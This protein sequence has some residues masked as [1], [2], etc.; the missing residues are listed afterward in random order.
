MGFDCGFEM[1]ESCEKE[2]E[3]WKMELFMYWLAQ[4]ETGDVVGEAE[5]WM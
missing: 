4:V 1:S 2:E 5:M 3:S